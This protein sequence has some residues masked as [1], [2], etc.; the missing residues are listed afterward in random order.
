MKAIR[1]FLKRIIEEKGITLTYIASK[2]GICIDK[3]SKS[4]NGTRR[5]SADEFLRICKALDVSKDEITEL[6]GSITETP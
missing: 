4:I 6:S 5:L 3:L 1:S 2:T